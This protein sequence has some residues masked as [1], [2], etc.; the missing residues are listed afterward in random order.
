VDLV[1]QY[2]GAMQSAP[3]A[4]AAEAVRQDFL[5]ALREAVLRAYQY[6]L[7]EVGAFHKNVMGPGDLE[8]LQKSVWIDADGTQWGDGRPLVV[9]SYE[10]GII[11]GL[12]YSD[13]WSVWEEASEYLR[14]R[15]S[16]RLLIEDINAA[17]AGVYVEQEHGRP[18]S[19]LRAPYPFEPNPTDPHEM[20]MG[21]EHEREHTD[22]AATAAAIS[23]DH[24]EEIPDYYTRLA[25]LEQRAEA[26]LAPNPSRGAM[27]RARFGTEVDHDGGAGAER[28]RIFHDKDPQRIVEIHHPFPDRVGLAGD[29]LSVLYRTDKWHEDGDDTDYKHVFDE[30]VKVYEPWGGQRWLEETKFPRKMKGPLAL[31]GQC[32]GLFIERVDDGEVYEVHL[33]RSRDSWLFS[34]PDGRVL[35]VYDPREG[36]R[37]IIAGGDLTVEAEGIDH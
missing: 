21:M 23:C 9:V 33:P 19:P 2:E 1:E 11:P 4:A 8:L 30:G 13:G 34:A 22:D 37:A 15:Y 26:G 32:I 7:I 14:D 27:Q 20:A 3:D 28:Y 6:A 10:H 35:Y 31:L 5:G 17:V 12:D 24:L 36:F 29:A 25:K 16:R 18:R